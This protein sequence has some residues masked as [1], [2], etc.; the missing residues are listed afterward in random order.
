MMTPHRGFGG[1]VVRVSTSFIVLFGLTVYAGPIPIDEQAHAARPAPVVEFAVPHDVP[2]LVGPGVRALAAFS[3]QA[4]PVPDSETL[5]HEYRRLGYRLA[6]V[7][8][9]DYAVPRVFLT[10]LPKDLPGIEPVQL[11]KSLFIRSILPLILRTNEEILADRARI[12]VLRDRLRNDQ[13]LSAADAH[14]LERLAESYDLDR[15]DLG[16][17][18]HRHDVVPVGLALAQA[19]E[20]SGW[21]T[22]RFALH[23]NAVFGQWTFEKGAG[24]VPRDRD[25]GA[26]HEVKAFDTLADSVHQYVR[27]L[28]SHRAYREFRKV[29]DRMRAKGQPLDSQLLAGTMTRYSERGDAYVDSIV[30]LMRSNELHLLD[31]A[32]LR[33]LSG[34]ILDS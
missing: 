26:T 3:G 12:E 25:E 18:L 17:L 20:E 31:R 28:N 19:I 6:D 14:W 23:G 30:N 27:N 16:A 10:Q 5:L 11:R 2:Q 21:G 1:T 15:R 24:L 29:R 4:L 9:D 34:Q 13:P 33:D 32:R 7:R 8:R 22:S